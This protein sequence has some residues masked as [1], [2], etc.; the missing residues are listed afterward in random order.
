[1][2][3][4]VPKH[5]WYYKRK[6]D[7][8]RNLITLAL[9][10]ASFL[11]MAAQNQSQTTSWFTV[12]EVSPK[13]WALDDRKAVNIYLIEGTDS[14]MLIDTG[15]GVADLLS[16]VMKLTS[17]PLIVV[18]TH[19]HPDHAGANYQFDKI[20]I[21]AAD[22]A[23]ARSCNLKAAREMAA[24]NMLRGAIPDDLD[25]FKGR[26]NH[27]RFVPVKNGRIFNLGDRHIQVIETPGHT[28]GSI[29]LLD[30]E[31][32]LL[33]TGDNDNTVV[34]LFLPNCTPLSVYYK[35]LQSLSRQIA[36]FDTI[37]PGHGIPI[38]SDFINEQLECVKSILNHT[39][40]SEP[41]DTFAGKARLCQYR[42]A[43]VAYNP[44]N[45]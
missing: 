30:K 15:M 21:H 7:M 28:P 34:W 45:L 25:L 31:D 23:D 11:R 44:D 39:C 37:F 10:I 6:K 27:F 41:Y 36:D 17:K 5:N 24:K 40:N 1:M 9:I 19:G 2:L 35:S 38:K 32:K 20:Y 8:K 4:D 12:K 33:F 26:E 13:I 14:A 29:C 22:S 18:N 3:S 42:S 43:S 16:Q